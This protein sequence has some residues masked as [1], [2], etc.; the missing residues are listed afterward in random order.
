MD[1][2]IILEAFGRDF[3][4]PRS[5]IRSWFQNPNSEHPHIILSSARLVHVSIVHKRYSKTL[6]SECSMQSETMEPRNLRS[7]AVAF[8]ENSGDCSTEW[9]AETDEELLTWKQRLRAT[10]AAIKHRHW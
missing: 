10:R 7:R 9:S 5:R 4:L 1:S 2:L 8:E 6:F 3:E